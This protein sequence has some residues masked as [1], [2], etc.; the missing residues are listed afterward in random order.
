M[1]D[2]YHDRPSSLEDLFKRMES[3]QWDIL[4]SD[5]EIAAP[6]LRWT[7]LPPLSLLL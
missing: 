2:A 6:M 4:G 1:S 7:I 3:L 5:D